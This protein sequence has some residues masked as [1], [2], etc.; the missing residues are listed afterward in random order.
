ME[1]RVALLESEEWMKFL[2]VKERERIEEVVQRKLQ[3]R[4]NEALG[5][6]EQGNDTIVI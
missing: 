6:E 5:V 3:G 1:E 4:E 2:D